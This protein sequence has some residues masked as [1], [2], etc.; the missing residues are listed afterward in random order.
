MCS[1]AVIS[2]FQLVS[3][4]AE[5]LS[6]KSLPSHVS[7]PFKNVSMWYPA[8]LSHCLDFC[9]C[10]L[11]LKSKFLSVLWLTEACRYFWPSTCGVW[12]LQQFESLPGALQ[13]GISSKEVCVC[14]VGFANSVK[15]SNWPSIKIGDLCM[16]LRSPEL[17]KERA[18]KLQFLSSLSA[19]TGAVHKVFLFQLI[20][21][22]YQTV[23]SIFCILKCQNFLSAKILLIVQVDSWKISWKSGL[24]TG[25]N[26]L[27]IHQLCYKWA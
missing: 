6:K 4:L 8:V 9:I 1:I 5:Q 27:K 13:I 19:S 23:C 24:G 25:A 2:T 21:Y 3:L 18:P 16:G 14:A 10:I 15:F 26:R 12:S 17:V 11:L 20:Q 7:D 22:V